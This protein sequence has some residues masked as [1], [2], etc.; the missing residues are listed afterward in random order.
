MATHVIMCNR[1][2]QRPRKWGQNNH[3]L[4]DA[5]CAAGALLAEAPDA[6]IVTIS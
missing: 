5:A 1:L 6:G 2:P 3:W 4:G